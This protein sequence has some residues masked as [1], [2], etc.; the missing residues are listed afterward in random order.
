M[1]DSVDTISDATGIKR[2]DMLA[3]WEAVKAN[4]AKLNACSYHE[5]ELI[6]GTD[7]PF[8]RRYRCK[9]CGGDVDGQAWYWHEQGRRPAP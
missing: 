4:G 7:R 1:A 2:A 9:H 8:K 3:I 5:F 6:D